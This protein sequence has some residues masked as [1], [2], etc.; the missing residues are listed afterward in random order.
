MFS[1]FVGWRRFKIPSIRRVDGKKKT[2]KSETS[3]QKYK[4][5]HLVFFPL[6][7]ENPC[8]RWVNYKSRANDSK[9]VESI[10]RYGCKYWTDFIQ[11]KILKKRTC[12][13]AATFFFKKKIN[14]SAKRAHLSVKSQSNFSVRRCHP[15]R[16]SRPS[17]DQQIR[18]GRPQLATV[19][20][21]RTRPD[22]PRL[23]PTRPAVQ[24]AALC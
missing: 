9:L 15:R 11:P 22:L 3:F 12:N 6:D 23:G 14:R 24:W 5:N 13:A 21:R 20:R 7:S 1:L 4:G 17:L 16:V 10:V 8:H 18:H 19:N 2:N